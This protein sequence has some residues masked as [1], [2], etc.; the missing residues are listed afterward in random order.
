MNRGRPSLLLASSLLLL[1]SSCG[2]VSDST[3]QIPANGGAGGAVGTAGGSVLSGTAGAAADPAAVALDRTDCAA[4]READ[5]RGVKS[6]YSSSNEVFDQSPELAQCS[7]FNS[8]DGCAS[9]QF[10]FDAEGCAASVAWHG[11]AKFETL[12]ELRQC[13]T[14]VL[15]GARWP[16][17]ARGTLRYEESCFIR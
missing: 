14:E 15:E 2:R 5:C 17:L 9:I 6:E 8:W 7:M 4:R 11:P 13:L 3:P 1:G 12:P 16:C 10:G